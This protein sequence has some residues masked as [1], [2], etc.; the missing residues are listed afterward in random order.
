MSGRPKSKVYLYDTDGKYLREYESIS[1]FCREFQFSENLFSNYAGEV[2][3]FEDGR[4]GALYKIGREGILKYRR[5]K[6]SEYTKEYRGRKIA[7]S[8]LTKNGKN[9]E[10]AVYNLDGELIATFKNSY[11]AK[12]LMNIDSNTIHSKRVTDEGLKFEIK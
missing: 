5:Y 7:E 4:V 3:E 10:V 6:S 8:V 1:L 11:F 9:K 2:Y 12:K